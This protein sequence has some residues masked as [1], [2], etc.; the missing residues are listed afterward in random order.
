MLVDVVMLVFLSYMFM[1]LDCSSSNNINYYFYMRYCVI[2]INFIVEGEIFIYL[3]RYV[4]NVVK[5]L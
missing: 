4:E 3:V 5:V 2:F 1:I